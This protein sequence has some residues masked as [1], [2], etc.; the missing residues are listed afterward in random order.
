MLKHLSAKE[1]EYAYGM[2]DTSLSSGLGSSCFDD[3]LTSFGEVGVPS[4]SAGS[5]IEGADEKS[6]CVTDHVK[7]SVH[8]SYSFSAGA[9]MV[10]SGLEV[11]T[12]D[13]GSC[14]MSLGGAA[15]ECTLRN[16]RL[17]ILRNRVWGTRSLLYRLLHKGSEV[18]H[19]LVM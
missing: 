19:P 9:D 12:G 8:R 11:V 14:A 4:S 3:R 18:T 10:S 2:L 17:Y 5:L 6:I 13:I 1:V 16:S 7:T 15:V